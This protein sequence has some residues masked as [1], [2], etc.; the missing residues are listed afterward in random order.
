MN[1][2]KSKAMQSVS[3][4]SKRKRGMCDESPT[5]SLPNFFIMIFSIKKLR[6]CLLNLDACD[7]VITKRSKR[8]TDKNKNILVDRSLQLTTVHRP[9]RYVIA[10]LEGFF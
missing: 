2:L 4:G 3:E 6:K 1:S 5:V 9:I 8:S 10:I 7:E